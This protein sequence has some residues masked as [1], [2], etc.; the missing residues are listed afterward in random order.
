MPELRSGDMSFKEFNLVRRFGHHLI[1]T[2]CVNPP[3][4]KRD[5]HP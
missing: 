3:E 4:T 5:R 1:K 2:A